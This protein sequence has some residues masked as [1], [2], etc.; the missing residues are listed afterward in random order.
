M[1][2]CDVG[3]QHAGGQ[4]RELEG[5]SAADD[6]VPG[7]G[8]AVVADDEVVP[9]VSRSTI[10]PLASSPHCRPTT[11]VQGMVFHLVQ[12]KSFAAPP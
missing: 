7:V 2:E 4:Q 10:F 3:A 1:T 12:P 6:G 9:S 8:A 11:Q 5:L